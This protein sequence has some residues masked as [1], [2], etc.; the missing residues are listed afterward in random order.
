[1]PIANWLATMSISYYTCTL[2]LHTSKN[3]TN[4]DSKVFEQTPIFDIRIFNAVE[5]LDKNY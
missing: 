2:I 1:M 5:S 3:V 4:I